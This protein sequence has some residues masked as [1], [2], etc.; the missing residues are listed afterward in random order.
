MISLQYL[1]SSSATNFVLYLFSIKNKDGS[2]VAN[3]NILLID[4]KKKKFMIFSN[5]IQERASYAC[6]QSLQL[7]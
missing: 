7:R 3:A 2:P 4:Q 6:F 5:A 1:S